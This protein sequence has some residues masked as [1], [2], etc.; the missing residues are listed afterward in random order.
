[1]LFKAQHMNLS[2]THSTSIHR[3]WIRD[4]RAATPE[5]HNLLRSCSLEHETHFFMAFSA[6]TH[7]L[8]RSIPEEN[9]KWV[10]HPRGS[11]QK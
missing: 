5:H 2:T 4:V 9:E 7:I 6:V 1:M 3:H 10:R 8:L 11:T